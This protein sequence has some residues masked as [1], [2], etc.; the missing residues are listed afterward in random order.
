VNVIE[1]VFQRLQGKPCWNVRRGYGHFL[2][3]EFGEPHLEIREPSQVTKSV[4]PRVRK[5]FARRRVTVHGQWHLWIYC[6][7]WELLIDGKL[8]ADNRSSTPRK[9]DRALADLDGQALTGVS[10]SPKN[11]RSVFEFDLG[12]SLVTRR[13][14]R[15][16]EQWMLFEP[17]GHVLTVRADGHCSHQPGTI[18]P[19]RVRWQ[20]ISH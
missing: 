4:S 13:F 14:D 7:D 19:D 18:A 3:L 1:R 17:S 15:T 10:V 8:I 5:L 6:C 2:T 11:A 9:I 20:P 12:G 16:G